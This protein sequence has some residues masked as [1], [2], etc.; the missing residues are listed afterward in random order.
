MSPAT[1]TEALKKLDSYQIKVG[2]PDHP[3]D[4][5]TLVIRAQDLVGNVRRTARGIGASTFR[6]S[7]ARW[8][9][10]TGR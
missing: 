3:R 7:M 5:S 4:Y 1:K 2:Y 9:E 6:G 10:A 8:I